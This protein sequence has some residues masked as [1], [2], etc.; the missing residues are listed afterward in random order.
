MSENEQLQQEID[1]LKTRLADVIFYAKGII[2]DSNEADKVFVQAEDILTI[3]GNVG[4]IR[5]QYLITELK[6]LRQQV[7]EQNDIINNYRN[8]L[9]V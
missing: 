4:E 3:C 6:K 7:S 9:E 2:R 8:N 1:Q 5:S